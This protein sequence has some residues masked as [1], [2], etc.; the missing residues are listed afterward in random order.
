MGEIRE[1]WRQRWHIRQD[2]L[3]GRERRRGAGRPSALRGSQLTRLVYLWER[4]DLQADIAAEFGVSEATVR[5]TAWKLGLPKRRQKPD[6]TPTRVAL[7]LA[8]PWHEV[9]TE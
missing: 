7:P 6:M 5:R 8:A 2:R 4:G 9:G 1:Y 3:K